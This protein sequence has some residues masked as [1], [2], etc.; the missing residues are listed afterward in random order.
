[1][2]AS[3]EDDVDLDPMLMSA[4]ASLN[5]PMLNAAACFDHVVRVRHRNLRWEVSVDNVTRPLVDWLCTR[6]R[7]LEHALERARELAAPP[8]HAR[9][10]VVIEEGGFGASAERVVA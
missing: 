5:A 1:M 6:E 10:R 8:G 7:A 9:V 3:D 2:I 4:R